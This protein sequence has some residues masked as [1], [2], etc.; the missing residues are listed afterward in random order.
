MPLQNR[1]TPFGELEA[2]SARGTWMGNRGILH[3]QSK[4][5]VALWRHPNWVICK[6]E[7]NGWKRELFGAGTYSE[8]FFLDEATALAAGHRPC[9]TCRRERYKEFKALWFDVNAD[10]LE[11]QKPTIATLDKLM[12]KQRANRQRQKVTYQA[13]A[14][15]LPNGT[16]VS[17]EN[18]PFLLW[19]DMLRPWTH[20]GY[21]ELRHTVP[22]DQ[23]VDV[24]TPKSVVRMLERGF[25]PEVH[26]SVG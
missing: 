10:L 19:E 12:H 26:C 22:R 2:V 14:G 8:L 1:V 5:I 13:V 16:I 3:D 6:L 21:G 23:H 18:M 24:L 7:F 15:S 9:G 17:I 11:G 4:N 25:V 20:F